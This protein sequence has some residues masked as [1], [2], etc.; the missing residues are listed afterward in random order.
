MLVR[1]VFDG[2]VG[3]CQD[4]GLVGLVRVCDDLVWVGCERDGHGIFGKLNVL[5]A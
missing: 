1:F 5:T 4:D 2:R 3:G